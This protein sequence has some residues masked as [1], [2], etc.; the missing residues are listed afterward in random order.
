M[1]TIGSVYSS[2][3]QCYS[4]KNRDLKVNKKIYEPIVLRGEKKKYIAFP[5]SEEKQQGVWAGI[6]E[7]GL[8]VLG[9]DGNAATNYC[10]EEYG[11]GEKTWACYGDILGRC[12]TIREAYPYL[13]D[14]YTTNK[15]G[16]TGDIV[17][18]SDKK[19]AVAIE[20]TFDAISVQFTNQQR[21]I[22]RTNFFVNLTS[23]RPSFHSNVLQI[24]SMAR[25]E[26]V[27]DL[28]SQLEDNIKPN[29]IMNILKDVNGNKGSLSICRRGGFNEYKTIASV[30]F[31]V[32]SNEVRAY[33]VVNSSPDLTEYK[34]IQI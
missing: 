10:G 6:N 13:I 7:N 9:A 31:E 25:Y 23:L 27:M 34:M 19:E 20:Y 22:A 32:C 18:M 2:D 21:Y 17:I 8:S 33:Y 5:V 4:F 11:G 29:N 28:L 12:E 16:D 3:G 26:R 24:S 14:Y 1:C 15:I 30:I